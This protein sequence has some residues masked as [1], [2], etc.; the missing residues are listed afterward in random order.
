MAMA[1]SFFDQYRRAGA[2][3]QQANARYVALLEESC[4]RPL[5]TAER[6]ELAQ[7]HEAAQADRQ[8]LGNY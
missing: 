6:A 2:A 3:R 4:E 7:L 1:Q 8:I 5:T